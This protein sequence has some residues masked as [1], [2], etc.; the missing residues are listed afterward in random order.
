MYPPSTSLIP[1]Q[2]ALTRFLENQGS[3]AVFGHY[4]YWYLGTTPFRYLT[5]PILPSFLALL[6]KILPNLSL[7][8]LMFGVIGICWVIGGVG[9][10]LL[11]RRM[12]ENEGLGR[13][14]RVDL[15][16]LIPAFFYLFGPIAPFLFRFS[17]GLHLIAF[18]FLP[19]ILLEYLKYLKLPRR[20]GA[21]LLVVLI[22]FLI[23]LDT[24]IIPTL[25]LG[26]AA[27]FLAQVGWKKMED[28]LKQS[29]LLI[30]YCLLLVTLWYTPGYWF[31]LLGAPSFGGKGLVQVIIWLGKL[32]PAALAFTFAIFSAKFFKKRN[33][34]RD[35]CFYWLF[36][37]GFLTLIRFLSDPDFWLDWSSYGM[38]L[39]FGFAVLGGLMLSNLFDR[40]GYQISNIKNQIHIL[41]ISKACGFAI[42]N[43]LFFICIFALYF[44]I[45]TIVFSRYVLGTLQKDIA[46]TVEYRIGKQLSE[47]TKP[48]ERV[49]LS[50]TTA[51]WLNA[52]FDIP[53]VR[54]GVDRAAVNSEWRKAVW[55]IRD[56]A[57]AEAAEKWLKTLNVK[58]LVVHTK[59]SEEFYHDFVY[60]EKFENNQSFK[61]LFEQKGD[62]IYG[63]D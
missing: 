14:M 3:A 37:F 53:Q 55:E 5:G 10:Y 19:F 50:G 13:L 34:L 35:F 1:V 8:E 57:T 28:K 20:R 16:A 61:K 26:I 54:G 38:E 33:L 23:L 18:S 46:S 6:H 15:V 25:V 2:V 52:F 42:K 22:S 29:L 56:G 27:I 9:V 24:L 62:I 58:Y 17:D 44:L 36:I 47:I 43:I 51:F 41:K 21:I 4:P 49:F 59:E 40:Q 31:T 32:L 7:F 45:F 11:V 30:A 12:R 39:Q 60:P 63:V 48:G